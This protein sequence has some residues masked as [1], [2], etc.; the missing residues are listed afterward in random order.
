MKKK[1]RKKEQ[2]KFN[3]KQKLK[4]NEKT[5]TKMRAN[6][7]KQINKKNSVLKHF[8]WQLAGNRF[9]GSRFFR[10]SAGTSLHVFIFDL[11]SFISV[12][13]SSS[14]PRAN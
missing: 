11:N 3:K 13:G 2:Q 7:N 4:N 8:N 5:K 6:K 10:V 9:T 12:H 1:E 14:I